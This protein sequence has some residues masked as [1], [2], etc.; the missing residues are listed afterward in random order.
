MVAESSSAGASLV[1]VRP[2]SDASRLAPASAL[3]LDTRH[4]SPGD[5]TS[6]AFERSA[7]FFHKHSVISWRGRFRFSRR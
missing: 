2:A 3:I 4:R 6:L 5:R 1:V 7:A